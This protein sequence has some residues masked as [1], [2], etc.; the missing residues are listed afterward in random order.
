MRLP[1]GVNVRLL[2]PHRIRSI[3][4]ALLLTVRRFEPAPPVP[5]G[6][7][8]AMGLVASGAFSFLLYCL[9][10]RT[11]VDD[12]FIFYRVVEMV[13]RGHG[14]AINPGE[15]HLGITS[16]LWTYLLALL[17]LLTGA[18]MMPLAKALSAA[19]VTG[20]GLLC[21]WAL[22]RQLGVLSL[23]LPIA[24]ASTP[25]LV[26]LVG[27]ETA[28]V[29]LLLV[30]AGHLFETRRDPAWIGLVCAALYLA[31]P[32]G[33]MAVPIF[34]ADVLRREGPRGMLAFLKRFAP[35]ALIPVLLWHGYLF[36]E[37]GVL[38]PATLRAKMSQPGMG[39][40]AF[41]P[42]I[43][44][45]VQFALAPVPGGAI[46]LVPGLLMLQRSRFMAFL[47]AFT[48][49]RVG[50]YAYVIKPAA[51]PWY[52]YDL[53]LV[54]R[55]VSAAGFLGVLHAAVTLARKGSDR[56]ALA[57]G[58]KCL[59]SRATVVA[60]L[61]AALVGTSY[62]AR[63]KQDLLWK[64]TPGAPIA[65]GALLEMLRERVAWRVLE[66]DWEWWVSYSKVSEW[67]RTHEPDGGK[68]SVV[69]ME[70]GVLGYLN[71]HLIVHDTMG[72]ATPGIRRE[73]LNH[74]E[75]LSARLMPKY[76]VSSFEDR[77]EEWSFPGQDG[78]MMRYRRVFAGAPQG[79]WK[80]VLYQRI[81]PGG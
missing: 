64:R 66:P 78:Q 71:S 32:D 1:R 24:I 23:A 55:L 5:T 48:A 65:S 12:A 37:M 44:G 72:L 70:L 61:V 29:T 56:L 17:K 19:L 10:A 68:E 34:F 63:P 18:E 27:M 81:D 9:I 49:L 47:L 53:D 41:G 30:L 77:G 67:L 62:V 60:A 31:R 42:A 43:R 54:L 59:V 57:P 52:F 20:A 51:Y 21:A 73:E 6:P 80:G 33:A 14:P 58:A 4:A 2:L 16:A 7:A 75:R 39:W 22:R 35:A 11:H 8:Y 76:I 3:G 69:V 38:L 74:Y 79:L 36:A 46:F 13:L 26:E 25:R 40:T 15:H 28:L 50:A 45:F